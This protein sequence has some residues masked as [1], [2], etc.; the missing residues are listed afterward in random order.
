MRLTEAQVNGLAALLVYRGCNPVRI[1]GLKTYKI[2]AK[3][4]LVLRRKG[5]RSCQAR[6]FL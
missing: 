1:P 2:L 5:S 3:Q 6:F 4:G